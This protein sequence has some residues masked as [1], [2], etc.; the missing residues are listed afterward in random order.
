[1]QTSK[2]SLLGAAAVVAALTVLPVGVAAQDQ[3]TDEVAKVR[4][5]HFS[6]DA[7]AVDVYANGAVILENVA[8]PAAPGTCVR[9]ANISC[10]SCPVA[11]P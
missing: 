8:F 10:R 11:L 2:H 7:P 6:P 4:V 1:M 3:M 9:P 5:G